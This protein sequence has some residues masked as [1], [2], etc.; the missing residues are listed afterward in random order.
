MQA[1]HA[2]LLQQNYVNVPNHSYQTA[3]YIARDP[4]LYSQN[5]TPKRRSPQASIVQGNPSQVPAK[6]LFEE[7]ESAKVLIGLTFRSL[8]NRI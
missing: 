2:Q 1:A 4:A 6:G 8:G 3:F 7:L 5:S